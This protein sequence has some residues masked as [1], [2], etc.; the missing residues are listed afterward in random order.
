MYT[1][2]IGDRV[3]FVGNPAEYDYLKGRI[4]LKKGDV[5]TVKE[6]SSC[7][8]VLF[9]KCPEDTIAILQENL[10]LAEENKFKIG[11]RV[12]LRVGCYA[13]GWHLKEG[14]TGAIVGIRHGGNSYTVR[15]DNWHN[16]H[17]GDVGIRD[18]SCLFVSNTDLEPVK[19]PFKF[20]IVIY[21]KDNKVIAQLHRGKNVY[22]SAEAKCSPE[23]TFDFFIGSQ[24]A[25]QRLMAVCKDEMLSHVNL[26]MPT[27]YPVGKIITYEL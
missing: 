27:D 16:G 12:R 6:N 23:D 24:I 2:K 9:D 17:D 3:K 26:V 25:L 14:T 1:F 19:E 15:F 18:H 22:A 11:D 8:F 5:A 4:D 21:R 20:N 13:E 7:P 10:E